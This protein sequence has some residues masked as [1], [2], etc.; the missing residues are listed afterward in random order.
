MSK[1][2]KLLLIVAVLL[3]TS[4]AAHAQYGVGRFERVQIVAN[5]LEEATRALYLRQEREWPRY[6]GD[7]Q[8]LRNLYRLH[9][10]AANFENQ[11]QRNFNNRQRIDLEYRRFASAVR[12]TQYMFD[13]LVGRGYLYRD[14]QVV[15]SLTNQL[16]RTLYSG[17]NRYGYDD[18][19]DR[20]R[21]YDDNDHDDDDDY[22]Y[23][24][25]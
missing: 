15:S 9:N 11:V 3:V 19:Y 16:G 2:L 8:I 20:D 14:L 4:G 22:D 25:D 5:D 10:L 17:G 12:E 13:R 23:D 1:S 24:D 21:D 6:R 18:R 7:V